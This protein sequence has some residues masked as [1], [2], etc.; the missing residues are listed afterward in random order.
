MRAVEVSEFGGPRVL[1]LRELPDPQAGAGEVLIAV[2]VADVLNMDAALRAGEG[3]DFFDL[4]PPYVPGGGAG[5]R[6]IAVGA[7]VDPAWSGRR[8]LARLGQAG[9]C[10][11]LAVAPVDTLVEVP[12]GLDMQSAAALVHDGLTAMGLLEAASVKPGERALV[13][14]AA[15]GMGVLLVQA[16]LAAGATVVGAVRGPQKLA[17]VEELGAAAVDYDRPE[18]GGDA[19]RAAGGPFDAVFDGVGG[20]AGR[21]AFETTAPGGRFS[22]HG[23]AAGDFAPVDAARAAEKS[24]TL[25]GIQDVW[26]AP[27]DARRLTESVLHKARDGQLRPFI[28]DRFPLERVAEAHTLIAERRTLGKSLILVG[29]SSDAD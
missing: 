14:A 13:T 21:V 28:G 18:W 3:Q 11:E 15:G 23:A 10:A 12:D 1:V 29:A 24:V 9:A 19:L 5:G 7:G 6:V 4:R 25:R 27:D 2:D 22:A 20:E 26:F 8:V 17:L 16:L